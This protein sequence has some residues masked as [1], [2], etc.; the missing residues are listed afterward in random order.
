M[1]IL[2]MKGHVYMGNSFCF[3]VVPDSQEISVQFFN[4]FS[5]FS[6]SMSASGHPEI[7]ICD[8]QGDYYSSQTGARLVVMLVM[9]SEISSLCNS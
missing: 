2:H 3:P 5:I 6:I 8:I 7:S 1:G 9:L 4:Q